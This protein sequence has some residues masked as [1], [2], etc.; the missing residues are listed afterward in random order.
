MSGLLLTAASAQQVLT[1]QP[2]DN[3]RQSFAGRRRRAAVSS[4][5]RMC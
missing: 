5:S 2:D 1:L 3:G 4:V